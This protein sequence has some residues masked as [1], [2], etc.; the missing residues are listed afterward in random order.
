[1]RRSQIFLIPLVLLIL[2][3]IGCETNEEPLR[4]EI[5]LD[6]VLPPQ[7]PIIGNT[8]WR[9]DVNRDGKDEWLALY[10]IDMIAASQSGQPTIGAL[11]RPAVD[12]DVHMPPSFVPALLWLPSQ[13][14]LCLHN[15]QPELWN[16]ITSDAAPELVIL[17]T[18]CDETACPN[19][20]GAAIF[21][22]ED[23][24]EKGSHENCSPGW[25]PFRA[26]CVPGGFVPVGHFRADSVEI[27]PEVPDRVIIT[28]RH[29]D[30]SDLATREIYSPR[31]GRYYDQEVRHVYEPQAQLHPPDEAEVIFAS[32]PPKEPTRAKLPEKLVMSFY[33][34]YNNVQE[35]ASY[36]TV[37]GWQRIG[38][39]CA[40][41]RCGCVSTRDDVS[42]VMVKRI[43]YEG[44]FKKQVEVMVDVIC[45]TD[46]GLD[47]KQ[48]V[49]WELERQPD[50]TWRLSNAR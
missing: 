47:L 24:L 26:A 34:N 37:E 17:D 5:G 15:C 13:G 45:V 22:W 18:V 27:S 50:E 39:N 41:G 35:I 25:N 42:R 3:L 8:L 1:M 23:G 9:F 33:R 46:G 38:Q 6:E 12:Q 30:R 2:F 10:H 44:E 43:T 11:Y 32:G 16:V 48:T 7:L 21:R 31:A 36:F 40:D 49:V 28:H 29:N 4:P 19:T 20:V 14:Y